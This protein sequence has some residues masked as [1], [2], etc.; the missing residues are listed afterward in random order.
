MEHYYQNIGEDWF[1]YADFYKSMVEKFPSGSRF[2]E[3]GSWRGR[4]AAFL[5][6][7]IINSKKDIM[8]TCLDSWRYREN[9]E[10]PVNNQ[11]DFDDIYWEFIKN[12]QPLIQY[13]KNPSLIYTSRKESVEA[14]RECRDNIFDFI[15]I[16]AGHYYEDVLSDL[17]AW[18]PKL[19]EGGIISGHDYFTRVHPGVKYAV[20]D[21]FK[22]NVWCNPKQNIWVKT[23]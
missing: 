8:L 4:S 1:S 14:A 5:G 22:Y 20:D 11:D 23:K 3:V 19:K 21:F 9:T 7:E 6:V 16:D 18:Y 10:Q 13:K 12:M 17:N 2:L 15:F